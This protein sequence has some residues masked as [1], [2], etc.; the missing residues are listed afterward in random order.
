METRRQERKRKRKIARNLLEKKE[1]KAIETNVEIGPDQ[2]QL[3]L[4]LDESDEIHSCEAIPSFV[5]ENE[6]NSPCDIDF[7]ANK[8]FLEQ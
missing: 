2:C 1:E 3:V 7:T 5:Q 6:L 8:Q 4:Q